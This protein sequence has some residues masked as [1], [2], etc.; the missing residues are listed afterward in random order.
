MEAGFRGR[1]RLHSDV[2]RVTVVTLALVALAAT[3]QIWNWPQPV[4]WLITVVLAVAIVVQVIVI[5]RRT[6]A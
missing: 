3:S 6:R 5:R 4:A 2:L 1:G